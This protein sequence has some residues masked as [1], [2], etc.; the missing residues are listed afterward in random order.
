MVTEAAVAKTTH[1]E[2]DAASLN[3]GESACAHHRAASTKR[4]VAAGK[5]G[6]SR[7]ASPKLHRDVV[8]TPAA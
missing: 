4:G 3:A 8:P 1:H 2:I 5:S 7:E 6:M